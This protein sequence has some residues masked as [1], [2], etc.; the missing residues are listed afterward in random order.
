MFGIAKTQGQTHCHP[1]PPAGFLTAIFLAIGTAQPRFYSHAHHHLTNS[2]SKGLSPEGESDWMSLI[3]EHTLPKQEATFGQISCGGGGRCPMSVHVGRSVGH[4]F[5]KVT[6]RAP[7][8]TASGVTLCTPPPYTQKG[9]QGKGR[10]R[11]AR[12]LVF[13]ICSLGKEIKPS[14]LLAGSQ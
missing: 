13:A 2:V 5:G 10:V 8:P 11:S 7:E 12:D 3:Y 9:T 4:P 14:T 1:H 6:L